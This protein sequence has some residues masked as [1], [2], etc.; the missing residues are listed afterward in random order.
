MILA[1]VDIFGA[2]MFFGRQLL[3]I[4]A[5][6]FVIIFLLRMSGYYRLKGCPE[7][8]NDLKRS[9]R[10]LS[11][12]LLTRFSVGILPLKRYRCYS[13]YWEGAAFEIKKGKHYPSS[14][15]DNSE[16]DEVDESSEN[17]I[18]TEQF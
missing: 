8:G 7:C 13:C 16:D 15:T 10:T 12:K 11:D 1:E 18:P 6:Y 2:V 4:V 5:I 9:Q 14:S 3:V 17:K